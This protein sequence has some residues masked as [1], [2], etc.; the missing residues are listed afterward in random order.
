MEEF[1]ALDIDSACAEVAANPKLRE[2]AGA[3]AITATEIGD[4]NLNQVFVFQA[5]QASK[6]TLL[7]K[8]ALPYL[9]VA[10]EGWP[11]TRER[12]RFET[13]SLLLH[14]QIAP[15]LVPEVFAHDLDNSWVAMEFLADHEVMRVSLVKGTPLR[16]A[17]QE[18]GRFS[19]KLTYH[20]SEMSMPA[21]DKRA[22]VQKYTNPD[23]CNL[24]EQF[25]FTNP[26]FLSEENNWIP[27]IDSEVKAARADGELKRAIAMAKAD[28]MSNTQALLHGD[29]H[30]GSVMVTKAGDTPA[31]RIID[32]EFAFYGP[33]AYDLGTLMANFAIGALTQARLGGDPAMRRSLQTELVEAIGQAWKGFVGEIEKL[34]TLDASG[35]LATSEYWNGDEQAFAAF[36]ADY[37]R[38]IA[39]SCGRHGGCELLRRCLGI[40]SVRELE[41]IEDME[42]RGEV[43]RQIIAIA[44]NWLLDPM[45]GTAA[46]ANAVDHLAA[47]VEAAISTLGRP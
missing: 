9:R 8:Q 14:N 33:V 44:R 30:T 38:S 27:A 43:E 19:A 46:L 21:R 17:G 39:A 41:S 1:R 23:L 5:A 32:P 18:I 36:R 3:G 24:Q 35:D 37:L 42:G 25:V 34:W 4:G 20:S 28:Y 29:L 40:V 2:I 7:L 22:L 12:M 47:R 31:T 26:F 11:L 16:N 10:G 13:E 15:D 6:P 45:P